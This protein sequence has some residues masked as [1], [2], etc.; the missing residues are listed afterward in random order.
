VDF[1]LWRA[2]PE[3]IMPFTS[4][5]RQFDTIAFAA[6][7]PATTIAAA[8][9]SMGHPPARSAVDEVAFLLGI[10][11]EVEHAF[12]L[13]YLYASYSL[14]QNSANQ[15]VANAINQFIELAR[16]EMGHLV[17][18]Q[19]LR[20][21]V[22]AHLD[23]NREDFSAHPEL[24]PFPAALEPVSFPKVAKYVTAEAPEQ[25]DIPQADRADAA[26]A[27]A[28]AAQDVP[29]I[30]RVGAVYAA[31]YWLFQSGDAPE[32]PWQLHPA[33]IAALIDRYGKGFH[34]GDG[35]FVPAATA[36][37]VAASKDE[38]G[39]DGSVYVDPADPRASALSALYR[40]ASQGEGP[41]ATGGEASHFSVLLNMYRSELP[42]FPTGSVLDIP[43]NPYVLADGAAPTANPAEISHPITALWA[44][45]LNTRYRILLLDILT[46]LSLSRTTDNQLR[47]TMIGGWA[48]GTEMVSF[49][50]PLAQGLTLRP[51]TAN[52]A[53]KPPF[54]GA[55][56]T[57]GDALPDTP[58]GQWKEQLALLQISSDLITRLRNSPGLAQADEDFLDSMEQ[59]DST[60]KNVIADRIRLHCGH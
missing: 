22:G 38:W 8:I 16:Q 39:G 45:L 59:F 35:D 11:A 2:E 50:S 54:A 21:A 42:A 60:R 5:M 27:A 1:P 31:L 32:G 56:F 52:P 24:Y 18:V 10:A 4:R 7:P 14:D 40:V 17:T 6:A 34:V 13:Q 48:V 20:R 25:E 9:R 37:D 19:N 57:F 26:R 58:C 33:D 15:A 43:V 3:E 29:K 23:F 30:R 41:A 51:R 44:R 36:A 49:I 28:E 46:A 55:P 47:Q 53:A 12:L